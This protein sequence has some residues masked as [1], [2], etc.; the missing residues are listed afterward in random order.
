MQVGFELD[1][2]QIDELAGMYWYADLESL[3]SPCV[4]AEAVVHRYLQHL[5]STRLQHIE[6]I[7]TFS[8]H[9]FKRIAKPTPKQKTSFRRS[10][11]FLDF[12]TLEA[13]AT[14]SFAEGLFCVSTTPCQFFSTYRQRA[15]YVGISS[16][17]SWPTSGLFLRHITRYRTA[18]LRF[19]ILSECDLFCLCLSLRCRRI[20]DLPLVCLP[21][22]RNKTQENLYNRHLRG[23]MKPTTKRHRS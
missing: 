15:H 14:Q 2:Y 5:A 20:L 18:P 7:R 23:I 10:F 17:R 1:I 16:S 12:A 9:R 11:S 8:M 22:L 4:R 19:A 3:R 21:P 13:S 6:R